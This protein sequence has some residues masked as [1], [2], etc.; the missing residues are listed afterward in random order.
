MIT[1]IRA[2]GLISVQDL[3]WVGHRRIGL[4]PGGAM[5]PEGLQIGNAL[6][7]NPTG[8]AGLEIV[9]GELALGFGVATVVGIVGPAAVRLDGIE[10]PNCTTLAVANGGRLDIASTAGS[11]FI[12][13]AIRGG[14][15]TPPILGSRSTYLPAKLGGFQGRPVGVAIEQN[16]CTALLFGSFRAS[17]QQTL[18]LPERGL[19]AILGKNWLWIGIPVPT[20]S[21]LTRIGA[22]QFDPLSSEKRSIIS[23]SAALP[24]TASV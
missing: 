24:T 18:M 21:S 6:V 1:V 8:D 9:Q 17:S 5:D 13:V 12:S 14:I 7:G 3:G 10:V 2:A 22:L 4:P 19:V 23:V 16:V 15:D 11:R 20:A